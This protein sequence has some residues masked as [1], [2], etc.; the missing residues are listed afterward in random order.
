MR[1]CKRC[2][3]LL[4]A[5]LLASWSS[6][7]T[8][9][10]TATSAVDSND[11]LNAELLRICREDTQDYTISFADQP[12]Q[13][14]EPRE[15]L[16]W[17][18]PVR[19]RQLGVVHLWL[20]EGRAEAMSTVFTN[21]A[22]NDDTKNVVMHEL[23]SLSLRRI[24]ATG[25]DGQVRWAPAKPGLVLQPIAGAA[26]PA[27]S[28]VARLRQMRT[29]AREFSAHS[30]AHYGET[31]RWEL[32]LLAQPLYR[33]E[34]KSSDVLDGAVFAFVSSAGTDPELIL[35]IEARKV[36]DRWAW[37][38]AGARFSDFSLYLRHRDKDVWSFLNE[39]RVP[40]FQA[41]P[42]DIYRLFRDRLQTVS[43]LGTGTRTE[44][45]KMR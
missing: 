38:A 44:A 5:W 32:R 17:T 42:Q 12:K 41:G 35:P 15:V 21:P 23:Q 36:N 2:H 26:E 3:L 11:K 14:F 24:T 33:Y 43:E 25:S 37:H 16:K 6:A 28:P 39:E 4:I 13:K 10:Q 9:A 8:S 27:D 7:T 40:E 45:R 22:L 18:N 19:H 30:I 1:A 20:H 34:S 31:A 29:L